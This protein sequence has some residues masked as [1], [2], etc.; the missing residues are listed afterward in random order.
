VRLYFTDLMSVQPTIGGE[1]L[2]ALGLSPGP[3]FREILDRIR[4]ARLDGM[5]KTRVDELALAKKLAAKPR[6]GE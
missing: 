4:D 1:D 5:V 3:A 2:I 6:G